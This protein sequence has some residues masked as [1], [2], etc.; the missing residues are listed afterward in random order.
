ME[1]ITE[2]QVEYAKNALSK[3]RYQSFYKKSRTNN[4]VSAMKNDF[5]K[6]N[7]AIGS[8]SKAM[9]LSDEDIETKFNNSMINLI[10]S[11]PII[12]EA[13]KYLFAI[14]HQHGIMY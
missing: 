2:L 11:K 4:N 10:L 9:L 12:D 1:E 8:I 14:A 6:M 5:D 3:S 7:I 13:E